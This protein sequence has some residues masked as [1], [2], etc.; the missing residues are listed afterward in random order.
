[1]KKT[2]INEKPAIRSEVEAWAEGPQVRQQESSENKRASKAN[3][4]LCCPLV[5]WDKNVSAQHYFHKFKMNLKHQ[6]I[7]EKKKGLPF[8][9]RSSLGSWMDINSLITVTII[10][11]KMVI[12]VDIYNTGK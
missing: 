8:L 3:S 1:M 5:D 2:N 7:G 10:P 6:D 12:N 9:F 11:R 4:A